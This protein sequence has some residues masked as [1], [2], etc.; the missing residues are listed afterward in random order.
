[1]S[2]SICPPPAELEGLFLGGLSETDADAIEQH[3]QECP[4]CDRILADLLAARDDLAGMLSRTS[5]SDVFSSAPVVA[6]L[7]AKIKS[8]S[9]ATAHSV[10]RENPMIALSCS[11]CQKKLAVKADLAGK[12]VKCPGCGQLTIVPAQISVGAASAEDS[13]SLPPAPNLE[14][15]ESAPAR[16]DAGVAPTHPPSEKPDATIGVNPDD[17]HDSSLTEFLAPPQADD[18]L[19]RL[20]AFRI[21]KILGHGGM[22]VVF[23]GEDARLS[24]KVA[25]KAMLPHLAQSKSSRQRF[26][27]EARAAAALEHD[28]IVPI[29]HVGE[30][31][32]APYIVMPFLKGQPLDERLKDDK[33][34]PLVDILRIGRE[35]AEGL[36][37]AHAMG[38]IHRDIKPANIWLEDRPP[39]PSGRGA[40]GEGRVKILDFGL[41]RATSQDAGLTQQGAIVG[42]PAYMAP[43]QG[44]GDTVDHRCDL[45]S[46]GV[47]LY[48]LCTGQQPFHGK[49]TVST[50]MAVAMNAPAAPI[51][52][53]NALSP[54]LSDLVLKLLEKDIDKRVSSA[55]EVIQALQGMEKKLALQKMAEEKTEALDA[56]APQHGIVTTPRGKGAR[57]VAAPADGVST[58]DLTSPKRGRRPVVLAATLLLV[59]LLGGGGGMLLQMGVIRI[60]NDRGDYVINT[61]DP[62]FKFSVSKGDVILEDTKTKRM[63]KLKVVASHKAAG[64]YEL[65]VTDVGADLSFK[66]KQF[67][68]KRGEQFALKAMFEPRPVAGAFPPLDPDWLKEVAAVKPEQ[69]IEAV[70]AELM[71]RNPGFDG[72]VKHKLNQD[73]VV[74]FEFLADNVTDLSPVQAFPELRVLSIPA[75]P[76]G[77]LAD[78]SPLKGMQLIQLRCNGN[79]RISDLTPLKGMKLTQLVCFH[80]N[81]SDLSPLK[82][83]KLTE[84]LPTAQLMGHNVRPPMAASSS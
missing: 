15:L 39:S 8:L 21:L 82:D 40:G 63:Y 70:K 48:R 1:M 35:V 56:G 36:G 80:T 83:M 43:E 78:L 26:L 37:A 38:L 71:K 25:I 46:L 69:Q 6:E 84:L 41:A 22:G 2:I 34:L 16:R 19:G 3:V 5:R 44:R 55:A 24:R 31:R 52:L 79:T 12:Q 54:E 28:H 7:V 59:A 14:L 66:V 51:Q 57:M 13:C 18:E 65:D 11:A 76:T 60:S 47:V 30:D 4:S 62:D 74:E 64:E 27:R 9:T 53:N 81:V 58:A 23:L 20:G 61:D 10:Q 68:I 72:T 67:T 33:P 49:D 75:N 45:F 32:G 77:Q 73:R 17:G 50:L 29:F 42:T